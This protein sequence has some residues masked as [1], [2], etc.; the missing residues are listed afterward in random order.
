[1]QGVEIDRH[2]YVSDQLSEFTVDEHL[3]HG[4]AQSVTNLPAHLVH[5][6]D[7]PGKVA[8]GVQPLDC[9]LLP[10]AGNAG[11]IVARVAA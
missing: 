2:G 8:V 7:Q 1:M 4:T 6:I 10:Y 5:M 9:G 3:R 11:K